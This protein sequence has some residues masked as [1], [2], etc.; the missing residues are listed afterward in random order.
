MLIF[1]SRILTLDVSNRNIRR[2]Y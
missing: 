1:L 2:L